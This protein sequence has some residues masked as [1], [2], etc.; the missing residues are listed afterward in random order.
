MGQDEVP[1]MA[2]EPS[3]P[4]RGCLS[5]SLEAQLWAEFLQCEA[6]HG[7]DSDQLRLSSSRYDPIPDIAIHSE[8]KQP[9]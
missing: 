5:E 9:S 2:A 8:G 4:H 6:M 3:E 1:V 7:S